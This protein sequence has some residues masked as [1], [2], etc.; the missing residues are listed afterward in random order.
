MS[1]TTS[2]NEKKTRGQCHLRTTLVGWELPFTCIEHRRKIPSR[3]L[4][5]TW[6]NVPSIPSDKL[7]HITNIGAHIGA[8][9]ITHISETHT[10]THAYK[11]VASGVDL[12]THL[13]ME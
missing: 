10:Y 12:S 8:N 3:H 2:T 5:A 1:N 9:H 7:R 6:W 4:V 11:Y 13:A